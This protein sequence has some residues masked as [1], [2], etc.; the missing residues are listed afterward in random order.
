MILK[1]HLFK[2]NFVYHN[3]SNRFNIGINNIS[4]K[5][6]KKH[7]D[8]FTT[9]D[10][11]TIC[12]DDAYEDIYNCAFPILD[13]YSLNKLIFP[14][15]DYIGKNN[16]W[17]VNFLINKKPHINKHQLK[18]LSD[19]GWEIGSH[20][21]CHISYKTLNNSEIYD[22]LSKSKDVLENLVGK[23]I[24]SF[25]PPF[26]YFNDSHLDLAMKVGYKKIYL[27]DCYIKKINILPTTLFNRFNIYK[28]DS[29]H[30][31]KRKI[32]GDK[33]KYFIDTAIHNCSNATVFVKKNS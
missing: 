14:I 10:N 3:I 4:P 12:F 23:E 24:Q 1:P 11:A 18:D 29:I 17:D 16:N 5:S 26:G 7:L 8:F 32:N 27:N 21:A 25:T 20:G 33:L 2:N 30:S 15:S 9:L 6:F 28:H 13:K 31:I 22:D 19:K